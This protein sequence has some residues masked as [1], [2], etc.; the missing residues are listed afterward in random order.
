M[1]MMADVRQWIQR[2][3]DD[4]GRHEAVDTEVI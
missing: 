1:M 2:W 3:G 4:D